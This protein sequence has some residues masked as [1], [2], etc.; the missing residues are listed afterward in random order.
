MGSAI[1][2]SKKR[3]P[4]DHCSEKESEQLTERR[5]TKDSMYDSAEFIECSSLLHSNGKQK[6]KLNS[7][8]EIH[9][10]ISPNLST[11]TINLRPCVDTS[12]DN[13]SF[14]K[15]DNP[16]KYSSHRFLK[17]NW[18]KKR[19]A[20]S[21]ETAQEWQNQQES[22]EKHLSQTPVH[23]E[24]TVQI[25]D[26]VT[27]KDVNT[28]TTESL[29][30]LPPVVTS[31]EKCGLCDYIH[32]GTHHMWDDLED[33]TIL[34]AEASKNIS[35]WLQRT[36]KFSNKVILQMRENQKNVRI[37]LRKGETGIQD[38][39]VS[40]G[41]ISYQIQ[42][43]RLGVARG[44]LLGDSC[45]KLSNILRPRTDS[46]ILSTKQVFDQSCLAYSEES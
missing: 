8:R 13:S 23:N 32:S 46:R 44:Q 33:D 40:D 39:I 28:S 3:E 18:N 41:E 15:R 22:Q 9:P 7:K 26:T 45:T 42:V 34:Y 29:D 6:A 2:T 21:S 11:K 16:S 24:P 20:L 10:K 27:V 30:E 19:Q 5:D 43:G 31:D 37:A 25:K 36:T 1:C 14:R 4:S 38:I 17:R 12:G 35:N